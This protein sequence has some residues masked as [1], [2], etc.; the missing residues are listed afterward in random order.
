MVRLINTD[1]TNDDFRLLVALLDEE[2]RVRDGDDHPFFAQFNTLDKIKLVILAF[3]DD[4]A[5]GCGACR[6]YADDTIEIKRMFV[7]SR[8]R[9]RGIASM[10]LS[11][12]E[13]WARENGFSNCILETGYNQPEAIALYKKAGYHIIPNYGPYEQVT[14]SVC[15]TKELTQG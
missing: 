10:V 2:L 5:V 8:F 14:N 6:P 1:S 11:G 3:S 9:G 7:D 4:R 15:F 12:L 13:K